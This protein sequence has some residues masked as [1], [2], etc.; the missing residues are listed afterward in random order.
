MLIQLIM[1]DV[2]PLI[3]HYLSNF[4]ASLLIQCTTFNLR[5]GSEQTT[6]WLQ[7]CC[8]M[9]W[10]NQGETK[11]LKTSRNLDDLP[12]KLLGDGAHVSLLLPNYFI[13]SGFWWRSW[14]ATIVL[15]LSWRV[16][17]HYLPFGGACVGLRYFLQQQNI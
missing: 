15:L 13:K 11:N 3:C 7:I 10:V 1:F 4:M 12:R 16:I 2:H 14:L 8:H 6:G 17:V 5:Q 9:A